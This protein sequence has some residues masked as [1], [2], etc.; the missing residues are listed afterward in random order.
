[1]IIAISMSFISIVMVV[2]F[3]LKTNSKIKAVMKN[4]KLFFINNWIEKTM[5]KSDSQ[6]ENIEA[7]L[8]ENILKKSKTDAGMVK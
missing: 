1:M 8:N 6:F 2:V 7:F 4:F 5:K 3:L